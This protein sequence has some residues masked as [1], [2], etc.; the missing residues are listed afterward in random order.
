MLKRSRV[1]PRYLP[2]TLNVVG[3]EGLQAPP[4]TGGDA[5]QVPLAM[6]PRVGFAEAP[7]SSYPSDE[8]PLSSLPFGPKALVD[9]PFR[10]VGCDL[11]KD[12]WGQKMGP[13]RL[14]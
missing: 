2:S 4:V 13:G 3:G 9:V 14:F 11:Q 8:L 12:F 6:C 10:S 1:R 5:L 7:L